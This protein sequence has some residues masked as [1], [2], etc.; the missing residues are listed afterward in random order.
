MSITNC[1]ICGKPAMIDNEPVG[2]IVDLYKY[3]FDGS[4]DYIMLLHRKCA[5]ARHMKIQGDR[6]VAEGFDDVGPE[7]PEYCVKCG[8]R[9]ERGYEKPPYLCYHCSALR[10][11]ADVRNELK[12]I[13]R[14]GKPAWQFREFIFQ[15]TTKEHNSMAGSAQYMPA[16]ELYDKLKRGVYAPGG[17]RVR[18]WKIKNES[19]QVGTYLQDIDEMLP[20]PGEDWYKEDFK[21]G[22]KARKK[23]GVKEMSDAAVAISRSEGVMRTESNIVNNRPITIRNTQDYKT[24]LAKMKEM[25]DEAATGNPKATRR[26]FRDIMWGYSEAINKWERE[27]TIQHEGTM[28]KRFGNTILEMATCEDDEKDVKTGKTG[29]KY[30]PVE[31]NGKTV[32]V[33]VPPREEDEEVEHDDE[34]KVDEHC[35]LPHEVDEET[36]Q[37]YK[38]T[39]IHGSLD[40]HIIDTQTGKQVGNT[41]K[42]DD[43]DDDDDN[44]PAR[45]AANSACAKLNRGNVKEHI[46]KHGS[47]YR[48]M[49]HKG[50]NLGTFSSKAAAAKHERQVNYFKSH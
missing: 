48:L 13:E 40:Y 6:V 29:V 17:R 27:H 34:D 50:K 9:L 49:S 38:I 20:E 10:E 47:G 37:R 15:G 22:A 1:T 11:D 23:R 45:V 32:Y 31:R 19:Q 33:T 7:E 25:E 18:I 2:D 16:D 35:G 26:A 5:L 46:V 24:A 28:L 12:S 21:V 39:R 44:E 4:L 14:K 43:Y 41:Y 42:A 36:T 30:Y 3:E 8:K